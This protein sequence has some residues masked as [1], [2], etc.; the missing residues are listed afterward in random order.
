MALVGWI[1]LAVCNIPIYFI[2]GRMFFKSW[3]EL[4]EAISFLFTP[5][6]FSALRGDY[7]NDFWCTTKLLVWLGLCVVATYYEAQ[8]VV[9]PMILPVLQ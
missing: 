7:W 9:I 8:L 3:E 4:E 5:S 6:F 1:I 2:L